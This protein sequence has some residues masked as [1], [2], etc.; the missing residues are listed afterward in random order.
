MGGKSAAKA[1]DQSY[2]RQQNM[3]REGLQ[4][5]D[6]KYIFQL[7]QQFL[8]QIMSLQNPQYQTAIQALRQRQA[9]SG[10]AQSPFGMQQEAGLRGSQINNSAQQA[11][12]QAMGLAQAQ[13]A[14]WFGQQAPQGPAVPSTG[15][16]LL[17]GV[18]SGI[19]TYAYMHPPG[20]N[21]GPHTVPYNSNGPAW[22]I[23]GQ[24]PAPQNPEP[25]NEPS[26]FPEKKAF[27]AGQFPGLGRY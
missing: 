13:A 6:P 19:N 27:S 8:P 21:Y 3:I 4:R 17:E 18:M 7:A 11:F 26:M 12:M 16:S 1:A 15:Q 14:P 23:P 10:L 22:T 2:A 25:W 5:L 20:L 24:Q 9:Q